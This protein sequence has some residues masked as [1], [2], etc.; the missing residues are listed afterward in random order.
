MSNNETDIQLIRILGDAFKELLVRFDRLEQRGATPEEIK[1]VQDSLG[2]IL[3]Q[4]DKLII[5]NDCTTC[6]V[7]KMLLDKKDGIEIFHNDVR[8]LL[9]NI[10]SVLEKWSKFWNCLITARAIGTYVLALILLIVGIYETHALF[11]QEIVPKI[12]TT[13]QP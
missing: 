13:Q 7:N 5:Q 2:L 6:S 11:H 9:N 10:N 3:K 4:L 12:N 8:E 1:A